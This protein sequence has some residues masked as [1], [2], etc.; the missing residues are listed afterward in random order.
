MY[1]LP[2]L[3]FYQEIGKVIQDAGNDIVTAETQ[4]KQGERH[5]LQD[6]LHFKIQK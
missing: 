6:L 4:V 3:F 5:F 2:D 1:S